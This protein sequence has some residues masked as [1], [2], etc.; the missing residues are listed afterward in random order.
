MSGGDVGR[1]VGATDVIVGT[2]VSCY[3]NNLFNSRSYRVLYCRLF[4]AW[5]ILIEVFKSSC[6]I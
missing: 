6:L 2:N 4:Y 5:D 3:H 1:S